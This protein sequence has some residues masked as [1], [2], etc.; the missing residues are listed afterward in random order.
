MV[1]VYSDLSKAAIVGAE[2]T[3]PCCGGDVETCTGSCALIVPPVGDPPIEVPNT[4]GDGCCIPKTWY[5]R[6]T[7][8]VP[9]PTP[10]Q[11]SGD[12]YSYKWT[13]TGVLDVVGCLSFRGYSPPPLGGPSSWTYAAYGM[14]VAGQGLKLRL[15][16]QFRNGVTF[17]NAE[18]WVKRA[19]II[20]S[21]YTFGG[22]FFVRVGVY[23]CETAVTSQDGTVHTFNGPNAGPVL[24]ET[25]EELVTFDDP[26]T[27]DSVY[28]PMPPEIET[29]KS[30]GTLAGRPESAFEV[31]QVSVSGLVVTYTA[32]NWHDGTAT[33]RACCEATTDKA[34]G[35]ATTIRWYKAIQCKDGV[36]RDDLLAVPGWGIVVDDA[37]AYY[38]YAGGMCFKFK[39]TEYVD[40]PLGTTP[41]RLFWFDG[42][43]EV[44]VCA[45]CT[46][47]KLQ[48]L[49]CDGD[50]VLGYIAN[51][52][53][54]DFTKVRPL[55]GTCVH[56]GTPV[57]V[58]SI[59]EDAT[60]FTA[61]DFGAGEFADCAHC[62]P[63]GDCVANNAAPRDQ[64]QHISLVLYGC[65]GVGGS[66]ITDGTYALDPVGDG[67]WEYDGE[68]F[69]IQIVCSGEFW[70]LG[71]DGPGGGASWQKLR[72]GGDPSS[73]P[74][75]WDIVDAPCTPKPQAFSV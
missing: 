28:Q 64:T 37:T 25:T 70:F 21:L 46:A 31:T 4:I 35:S 39:D 13:T 73:G 14:D 10:Y 22:R 67:S 38:H 11:V 43:V 8:T 47:S 30:D 41:D 5:V 15:F 7:G 27:D 23:A 50:V 29:C 68:D 53:A 61:D 45:T 19:T 36:I 40:Y 33:I 48:V 66:S 12:N 57:P 17:A 60:I 52:A 42:Y 18:Y 63:V 9:H 3:C 71:I 54:V 2:A 59:P 74:S 20:L 65:A 72:V 75:E 16:D 56:F 49:D 51:D 58:G 34:C 69:I 55:G 1:G 32:P 24:F 44:G 6:V 62:A 26:P